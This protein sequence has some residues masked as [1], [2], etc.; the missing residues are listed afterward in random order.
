MSTC[1]FCHLAQPA[2]QTHCRFSDEQV[3]VLDDINPQAPIHQLIIPKKHIETLNALAT[4][5][6]TWLI[7]HM[8]QIARQQAQRMDIAERGYRTVFNCNRE[9]GQA[10]YHLHLHMLG[11]RP[12]G[13]PPG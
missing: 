6:D 1:L 7:G 9:G 8:F 2:Q 5:E 10:I 3:I 11:G 13:W 12:L 4:N